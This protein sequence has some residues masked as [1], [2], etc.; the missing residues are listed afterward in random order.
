[1]LAIGWISLFICIIECLLEEIIKWTEPKY[2]W[3]H[4]V[5]TDVGGGSVVPAGINLW[6]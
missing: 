5:S 3:K 2:D 6:N 4:S 1:M